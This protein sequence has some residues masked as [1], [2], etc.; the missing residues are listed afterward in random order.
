MIRW[1]LWIGEVWRTKVPKLPPPSQYLVLPFQFTNLPIVDQMRRTWHH[2]TDLPCPVQPNQDIYC[3]WCPS[4]TALRIDPGKWC[5]RHSYRER[6]PRP[7]H[8]K[9]IWASLRGM[10]Q[11]IVREKHFS[12]R[13]DLSI[14]LFLILAYDVAAM[15]TGHDRWDHTILNR[16]KF[17]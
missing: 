16:F 14:N 6:S 1:L 11:V 2:W 12:F 13:A 3:P 15:F 5:S 8:L 9:Y 4:P 10:V 7:C 17:R